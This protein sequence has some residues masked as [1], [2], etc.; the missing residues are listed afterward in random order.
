[1]GVIWVL[2]ILAIVIL[3]VIYSVQKAKE[4]VLDDSTLSSKICTGIS[5][6]VCLFGIVYNFFSINPVNNWGLRTMDGNAFSLA[7]AMGYLFVWFVFTVLLGGMLAALQLC[8]L[9]ITHYKKL[10]S[11]PKWTTPPG[12]EA[13]VFTSINAIGVMV[14]VNLA[15]FA[16]GM[17][18]WLVV[19]IFVQIIA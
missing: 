6:A 14:A 4:Y 5:F 17:S 16:F 15:L 8:A 3:Y 1:M 2:A 10:K 13:S 18:D 19:Q 9:I 7:A 12:G 11:L